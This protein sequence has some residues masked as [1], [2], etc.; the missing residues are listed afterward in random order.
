M[1]LSSLLAEHVTL[2]T[3]C[4]HERIVGTRQAALHR[5]CTVAAVAT[6][7]SSVALAWA[8]ATVRRARGVRADGRLCSVQPRRTHSGDV[9]KGRQRAP[10]YMSSSECLGR[11][12]THA[13]ADCTRLPQSCTTCVYLGTCKSVRLTS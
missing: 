8:A 2:I 12:G 3:G 10:L 6:V 4:A 5:R 9:E 1:S 7:A 13:L 11:K